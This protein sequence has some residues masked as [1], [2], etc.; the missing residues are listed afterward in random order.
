MQK[1]SARANRDNNPKSSTPFFAQN[2]E[3]AFFQPVTPRSPMPVSAK[4]PVKM[5]PKLAVSTP[6]D[7]YEQEADRIADQVMHMPEPQLQ[8]A[9]ACGGGCPRCQTE[10]PGQE[11]E[12]LQAKRIGSSDLGRT[13]VPPIVHEVLASPGQP[14][15]PTTRG[16]MEPRFARDF[17]DVRVHSDAPA[18]E[19]ASALR[20]VA[21][22]VGSDVVFARDRFAPGSSAGKRLLAHELAHVVQ[23]T[24]RGPALQLQDDPDVDPQA[25]GP[26]PASDLLGALMFAIETPLYKLILTPP[27]ASASRSSPAVLILKQQWPAIRAW[28]LNPGGTGRGAP[29][30]PGAFPALAA[31]ALVQVLTLHSAGERGQL[32]DAVFDRLMNTLGSATPDVYRREFAMLSP[33]VKRL[34]E[35]DKEPLAGY[36]AMREGLRRTFGSIRAVNEFYTQLVQADFPPRSRV[37]GTQSLVHKDLK[38]A[39][40]KAAALLAR[41]N[42]TD[43]VVQHLTGIETIAGH[44]HRRGYWATNIRENRNLPTSIGNHSFGFAIDINGDWNPNL[45]D[46]PWEH[47]R[48]LTG[49]DVYGEDIQKARPTQSFDTVLAAAQKFKAASDRFR[50][51][52]DSEAN[53][54]QAMYKEASQAGA[55]SVPAN[56]LFKAVVAAS[57][58]QAQRRRTAGASFAAVVSLLEKA[59]RDEEARKA[60]AVSAGALVDPRVNIWSS[61]HDDPRRL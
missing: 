34:L 53:P 1:L 14:L 10:Q 2:N 21:Y 48:R 35:P 9:C 19:S 4:A 56:D 31:P 13:A 15:D 7:V 55:P 61:A 57:E 47:V 24:R 30:V 16:F 32:A 51:I 27:K 45:R 44:Q 11:H 8:R 42:L 52:F 20:A 49:F 50:D 43:A 40:D 58:D 5:Q 37:F 18:A 26:D 36:V 17:G 59:M 38:Q 54:Q 39:L 41:K 6:E 33:L 28:I 12:R 22:T 23:Q 25:M 46:F 29:R 3:S 60:K